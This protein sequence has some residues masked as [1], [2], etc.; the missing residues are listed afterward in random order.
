MIKKSKKC[1]GCPKKILHLINKRQKAF[2]SMSEIHFVLNKQ[3]EGTLNRIWA[4]IFA[5]L[6]KTGEGAK[7][8]PSPP[9]LAI[10]SQMTMK[11]GKNIQ[12]V[13]IFT[14]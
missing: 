3:L 1:T 8:S 13:E 10:S 2:G 14:N 5:S 7:M 6:K 12:W 9:N 11:V 4:G